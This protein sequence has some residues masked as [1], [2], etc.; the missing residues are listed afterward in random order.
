MS[1]SWKWILLA[2]AA[3]A[4]LALFSFL[5]GWVVQWLWNALLPPLFGFP[6]ITFWQAL[7]LLALSRILFG[8]F[9]FHGNGSHDRSQ[10]RHQIRDRITDR[11]AD[12]VAE[13]WT[14]MTPEER[15]R[16]SQRLRE[17]CG[18]DPGAGER[19]GP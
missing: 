15:E 14:R 5:G 6:V 11:M 9:G 3:L 4:G 2:P 17:R 16:F 7:G 1:R 13:R 18:F 12:R 8:G 10:V 19:A